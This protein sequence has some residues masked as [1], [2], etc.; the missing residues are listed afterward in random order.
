VKQVLG[1]I[2]DMSPPTGPE[3]AP[4]MKDRVLRQNDRSKSPRCLNPKITAYTDVRDGKFRICRKGIDYRDLSKLTCDDLDK[5][6][7]GKQTDR[8]SSKKIS[9][10]AGT[11]L[12]ADFP[13][14][15]SSQA[16]WLARLELD[17]MVS[18]LI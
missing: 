11:M 12:H 10:I 8:M 16:G 6:R 14:S 5:P 2:V 1:R 15:K 18:S 3:I 7:R 4:R 9:S 13:T 17:R